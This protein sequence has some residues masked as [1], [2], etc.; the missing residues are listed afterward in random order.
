MFNCS[1]WPGRIAFLRKATEKEKSTTVLFCLGSWTMKSCSVR[2]VTKLPKSEKLPG[3]AKPS[4]ALKKKKQRASEGPGNHFPQIF[5]KEQNSCLGDS[6][7][8]TF[9][10]KNTMC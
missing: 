3:T 6:V 10:W 8:L 1:I 7:S 5:N 9:V 4:K 2:S